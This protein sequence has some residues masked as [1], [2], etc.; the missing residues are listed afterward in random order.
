MGC[1]PLAAAR[2]PHK[3]GLLLGKLLT[4]VD[5]GICTGAGLLLFIVGHN[6]AI[7]GHAPHHGLELG[8]SPGAVRTRRSLARSS[9]LIRG[10]SSSPGHWPRRTP[11]GRGVLILLLPMGTGKP[12]MLLT[13]RHVRLALAH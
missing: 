5:V 12:L 13:G 4:V 11:P 6:G 3:G 2:M 7:V 8:V 9:L 10:G 1:R